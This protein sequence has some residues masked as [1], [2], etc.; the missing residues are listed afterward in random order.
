[1]KEEANNVSAGTIRVELRYC[2]R[3]GALQVTAVDRSLRPCARCASLLAWL[4]A[5]AQR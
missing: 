2:E 1:M 5:G 3:C 4:G